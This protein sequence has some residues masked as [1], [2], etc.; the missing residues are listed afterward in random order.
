MKLSRNLRLDAASIFEIDEAV[1]PRSWS[2][3]ELVE[4]IARQASRARRRPRSAVS[5][6]GTGSPC[7]PN[8]G[9]ALT[10]RAG[11]VPRSVPHPRP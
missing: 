11:R 6:L 9:P 1:P 8:M 2:N 10:V 7:V 5:P 3:A 4:R